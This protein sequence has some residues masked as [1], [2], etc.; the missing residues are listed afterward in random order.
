MSSIV[1]SKASEFL[2]VSVDTWNAVG[3]IATAVGVLIA[4]AAG[5][6]AAVQ[7]LYQRQARLDQNRPYVLLS[8]ERDEA[9]FANLNFRIRNVGAGPAHN[10]RIMADPPL[11]RAREVDG[12]PLAGVRY[13]N[14]TIPMMP[15]GYELVSWF[16]SVI[17]RNEADVELPDRYTFTISYEDGH[18]HSWTETTVE[19]LAM[20]NDLLFM[21]RYT[22]HHAAKA[23]REIRDVVKRSPLAK[24]QVQ[25]TVESRDD[26]NQRVRRE[27]EDLV[28]RHERMEQLAA[29][30]QARAAADEEAPGESPG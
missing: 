19:D 10:V 21:E 14:E 16:D 1:T 22:M 11:Q 24:G 2:G 20:L 8:L 6:V 23:L 17:E 7:L 29:E 28:R 30:A 27:R 12:M 4:A 26:R 25:A 5:V 3:S 9:A 13:F 15:P 18:G